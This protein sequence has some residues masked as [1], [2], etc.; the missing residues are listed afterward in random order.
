MECG[1]PLDSVVVKQSRTSISSFRYCLQ[2]SH[3]GAA[4][5]SSLDLLSEDECGLC[6]DGAVERRSRSIIL[7]F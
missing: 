1:L 4:A 7:S 3:Q 2:S 5:L 6:L